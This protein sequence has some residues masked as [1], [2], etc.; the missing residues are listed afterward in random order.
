MTDGASRFTSD[1]RVSS[2]STWESDSDWA[3]GVAEDVDV[4]DGRLVGRPPKQHSELP[5]NGL[6]LEGFKNGSLS[7]EYGGDTGGGTVQSSTVY[8]GD[9]ALQMDGDKYDTISRTDIGIERG[10]IYS[11]WIRNSSSGTWQLE[12]G[13]VFMT[14][15]ATATPGGYYIEIRQDD[16]EV[17]VYKTQSGESLTGDSIASA[18]LPTS[19]NTWY[20]AEF[21]PNDDGTEDYTIYDASGGELVSFSSNDGEFDLGGLGFAHGGDGNDHIGYF[22]DIRRWA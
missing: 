20:E 6:L 14:Q 17:R 2:R 15:E 11:G 9:Y 4:V 5:D 3:A 13:I 8:A 10:N 1:R 12:A 21:K 18:S 16:G 7:S 22:D 19:T